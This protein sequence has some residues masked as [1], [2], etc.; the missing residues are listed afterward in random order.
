MFIAASFTEVYTQGTV[1]EYTVWA[2]NTSRIDTGNPLY[3]YVMRVA[4]T[5]SKPSDSLLTTSYNA[6]RRRT[7]RENFPQFT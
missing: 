3:V 2:I 5:L 6:D 7:L 4:Y 1:R